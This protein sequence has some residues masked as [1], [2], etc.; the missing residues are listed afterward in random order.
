[1]FYEHIKTMFF[2]ILGSIIYCII[3]RY[4]CPDY[5]C[6][7]QDK[8]SFNNKAFQNSIVDDI[9]GIDITEVLMKIIIC[10]VF[11]KKENEITI[12]KCCSKLVS[13]YLSK[14]FVTIDHESYALNNVP[15]KVKQ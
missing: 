1:M 11:S 8:L 2:N 15:D 3:D 13:Y 7:Q 12:L 14:V 5:L 10:C 9:S 6:L 4:I